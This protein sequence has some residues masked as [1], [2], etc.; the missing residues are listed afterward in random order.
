MIVKCLELDGKISDWKGAC[1]RFF[2]CVKRK[3]CKCKLIESEEFFEKIYC[4]EK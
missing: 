2:D 4:G 1:E 3:R